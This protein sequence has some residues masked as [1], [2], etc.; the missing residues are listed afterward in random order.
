MSF[1]HY[2]GFKSPFL[3]ITL[4]P[5][6]LVPRLNPVPTPVFVPLLLI[7][8][9]EMFEVYVGKKNKMQNSIYYIINYIV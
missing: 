3:Q 6:V 8:Y 9:G 1:S 2:P 4:I 7:L 5:P